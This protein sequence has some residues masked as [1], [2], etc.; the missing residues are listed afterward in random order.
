MTSDKIE[1]LRTKIKELKIALDNA[2]MEK[3]LNAEE[4]KDLREN[5]AYDYWDQ[6]ER[7]LLFKIRRI[8]KEITDFSNK[9]KS[10]TKTHKAKPK[11][12][13]KPF[14]IKPHKWI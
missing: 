8:M 12:D 3:G 7:D 5:S 4:N 10:S 14:D 11:P 2:T 9:N 13:K 6:K 1:E